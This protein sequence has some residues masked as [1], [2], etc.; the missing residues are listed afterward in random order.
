[1]Y[2]ENIMEGTNAQ[3]PA[4]RKVV[5]P[6]PVPNDT[7]PKNRDQMREFGNRFNRVHLKVVRWLCLENKG[8]DQSD[9][10]RTMVR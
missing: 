7:N 10:V 5:I 8:W 3:V 6:S 9:G 1:M 2:F 4:I